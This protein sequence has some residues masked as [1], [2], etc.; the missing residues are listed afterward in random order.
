MRSFISKL[1]LKTGLSQIREMRVLV[2]VLS[3]IFQSQN[4]S[5]EKSDAIIYRPDLASK[6]STELS[7]TLAKFRPNYL[8]VGASEVD[9]EALEI[10]K[11]NQS[12]IHGIARRGTSLASIDV[13]AAEELGIQVENIPAVNSIYV[14]EYINNFLYQKD[15]T[16]S[17]KII[18]LIGFGDINSL[19]ASEAI[20][21]GYKVIAYS[22]S[23]SS[24][25]RK[26]ST[27]LQKIVIA[28]K[29]SEVFEKA[30]DIAIAA[31]IDKTAKDSGILDEDCVSSIDESS[32]KRIICIS[33]PEVFSQKALKILAEKSDQDQ[34][35]I[36]FDNSPKSIRELDK[37]IT[38][39][40]CKKKNITFSSKAMADPDCQKWIALFWH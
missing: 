36:S 22:P 31:T 32:K 16:G 20:K 40:G 19:V 39:F 9:K 34:L 4:S 15:E 38:E 6:T 30:D 3:P 2:A 14:A 28:R 25:K 35:T 11:K 7:E 37:T 24:G 1:P 18:G 33:E 21:K 26:I 13:K 17:D 12:Q 27:D 10:W 5:L 23:L 29:S 8:V